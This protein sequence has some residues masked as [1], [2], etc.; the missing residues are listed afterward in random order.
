MECPLWALQTPPITTHIGLS[1]PSKA[2]STR[3]SRMLSEK[4]FS[5]RD[6]AN[7]SNLT[8]MSSIWS[9]QMSTK[10]DNWGIS[11]KR[12]LLNQAVNRPWGILIA[13]KAIRAWWK[14]LKTMFYR[15][16]IKS[17]RNRHKEEKANHWVSSC[18]RQLSSKQRQQDPLLTTIA[19]QVEMESIRILDWRPLLGAIHLP[20]CHKVNHLSYLSVRK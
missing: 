14:R 19:S 11:D 10:R 5:C 3:W 20:F 7:K 18:L 17:K 15:Q 6:L 2:K 16:L 12:Q 1:R 8:A 9:R 4:P 13:S